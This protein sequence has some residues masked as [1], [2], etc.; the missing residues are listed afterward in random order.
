MCDD[1]CIV[2]TIEDHIELD[3]QT[4]GTKK[5]NAKTKLHVSSISCNI[6]LKRAFIYLHG[7]DTNGF[8]RLQI[9]N[10]NK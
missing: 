8:I 1:V 3:G 4:R 7:F 6:S 9:T 10:I 5:K 2:T